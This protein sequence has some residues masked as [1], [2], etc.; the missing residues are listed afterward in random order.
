VRRIAEGN[1]LGCEFMDVGH[2][3]KATGFYVTT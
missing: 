2:F 1:Y 3:D